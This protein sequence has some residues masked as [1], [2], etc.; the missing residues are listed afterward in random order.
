MKRFG[1][2]IR[3]KPGSATAYRDFHAA[4][5]PEVLDKIVECNLR[6]YSIYFKDNLLFTYF[7]YH[8]NDLKAD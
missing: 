1:M 3:L 6:N 8:G 4:V 2:V 5:W 7:E